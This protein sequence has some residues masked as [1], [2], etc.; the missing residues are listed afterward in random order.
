MSGP[1]SSQT[2]VRIERAPDDPICARLSIGGVLGSGIYCTYRYGPGG[3]KVA[4]LKEL[5][6]LVLE[7]LPTEEQEEPSR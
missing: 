2:I 3:G 4:E 1:D 7:S 5:L 6:R